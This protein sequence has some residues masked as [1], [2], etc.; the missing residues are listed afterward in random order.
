MVLT[1]VLNIKIEKMKKVLM[2][3]IVI[4]T[5]TMVTS[6]ALAQQGFNLSIKST[7]QF[8]FLQNSDENDNSAI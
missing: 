8:S 7:P 6:R 1:K 5:M 4:A 2:S 3:A